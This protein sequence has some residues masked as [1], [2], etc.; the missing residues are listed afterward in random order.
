[1]NGLNQYTGVGPNTYGYDLNGNLTSDGTSSYVYDAENRLV[2]RSGGVTLSYDPNGRLWQVTGPDGTTRFVYDGDRLMEEYTGAGGWLRSY[3]HGAGPDEPLVWYE[4][5]GG[6]VRRYLHA[7]HQGSVIASAD[8]AGNVVGLAGY[9]EWGIPNSSA[10]TNVGR[11]GYTGQ[12]WIPELGMWYYKARIYSPMLGRFLQTDP[13]GYKD[14]VNL[15]AY[16]GNDPVD[17]RDPDGT[18]GYRYADRSC[19]VKVDSKTGAAGIAAGRALEARLNV[20]DKAI[21]NLNPKAIFT[22]QTQAGKVLGQYSGSQLQNRWDHQKFKITSKDSGNGG[23]GGTVPGHTNLRPEAV[24]QYAAAGIAAH[25][26]ADAGID[27]LIDHEIGHSFG[28][29]L[30]ASQ[31]NPVTGH[32]PNETAEMA[33]SAQGRAVANSIKGVFLCTLPGPY[34]C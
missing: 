28:P 18:C 1:V 19:Q 22:V 21:H 23:L 31:A 25:S 10:L 27:T 24:E 3:A 11:L 30:D 8:D 4:G 6:P 15:Y 13:V 33:A 32:Q 20:Q 9:D 34:G 29:G 12:A 14:Q 16:V 17:L 26:T 5:T 7:D 2:S